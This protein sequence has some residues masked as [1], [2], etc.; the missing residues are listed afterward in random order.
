MQGDD[1]K[2]VV[3]LEGDKMDSV[4]N[5][6][7]SK[8]GSR[9][10]SFSSISSAVMKQ[11]AKTEAAKIRYSSLKQKLIFFGKSRT[12]GITYKTTN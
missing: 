1:N 4:S 10:S 5:A 12:R 2:V 7:S 3:G 9:H 11:R 6:P 8:A